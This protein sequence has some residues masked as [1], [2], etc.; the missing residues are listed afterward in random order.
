MVRKAW[1]LSKVLRPKP[2]KT[3]GKS[4]RI[5][6]WKSEY[7]SQDFM[8]RW[9]SGCKSCMCKFLWCWSH[10]LSFKNRSERFKKTI[11]YNRCY[12]TI[13]VFTEIHLKKVLL[14]HTSWWKCSSWK[15]G[16]GNF[17]DEN[18]G[19]RGTKA[20]KSRDMKRMMQGL[21][22]MAYFWCS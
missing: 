8:Q 15:D 10:I 6:P 4:G 1:V 20:S 9:Q 17:R 22:L 3:V 16:T 12:I 19:G 5:L 2:R 11:K 18:K 21:Q 7:E 13:T 14:L